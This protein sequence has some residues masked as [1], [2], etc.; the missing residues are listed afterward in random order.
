MLQ[1]NS[2]V[3]AAKAIIAEQGVASI[4]PRSVGQ[5]AGLAR[6]SFYEYFP[7]RD[8][9]LAA[10]ALEAFEK[11][12]ADLWEAMEPASTPGERLEAYVT[13]TMRMTTSADHCLATALLQA[14]LSPR[15][16]ESLM[17]LHEVLVRP[18]RSLLEELEVSDPHE[19]MMLVQ[20]VMASGMR[21][22][23]QGGDVNHIARV[24]TN[25]LKKGIAR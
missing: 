1:R 21:L 18:L 8:D 17:Q 25:L 23:S 7:S 14:D 24:T 9:L 11:W 10:V 22:V 15:S 4:S 12:S 16:K 5:R 2:I 20:G 6:S 19:T 13:A 3:S